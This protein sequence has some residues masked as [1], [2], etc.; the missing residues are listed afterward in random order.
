L[1]L[2][3]P[4]AVAAGTRVR[5]LIDDPTTPHEKDALAE[6]AEAMTPTP[7]DREEFE[8][9]LRAVQSSARRRKFDALVGAGDPAL[10]H[11]SEAVLADMRGRRKT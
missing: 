2:E 8:A 3:K 10:G 6:L 11:D 7:Q 5:V 1:K 4:I 9:D